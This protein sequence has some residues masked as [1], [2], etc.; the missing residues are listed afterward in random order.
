MPCLSPLFCVLISGPRDRPVASS[1][2][3]LE[4]AATLAPAR[5]KSEQI[6]FLDASAAIM[7]VLDRILLQTDATAGGHLPLPTSA[8]SSDIGDGEYGLGY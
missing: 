4:M 2:S 1:Q 8:K 6:W 7:M 5:L 3:V